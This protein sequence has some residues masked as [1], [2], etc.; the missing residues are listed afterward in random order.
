MTGIS[1]LGFSFVFLKMWA[2]YTKF[3][4]GGG[5]SHEEACACQWM[6]ASGMC[7]CVGVEER[8]D[9]RLGGSRPGLRSGLALDMGSC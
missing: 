7:G 3:L 2:G 8:K 9:S 1:D 6:I 4:G 5:N